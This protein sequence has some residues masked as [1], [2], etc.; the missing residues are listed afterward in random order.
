[1]N[2][3]ADILQTAGATATKVELFDYFFYGNS[4]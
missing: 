2:L 1:M 4:A 3:Y